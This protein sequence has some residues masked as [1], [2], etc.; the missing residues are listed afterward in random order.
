MTSY[1][2]ANKKNTPAQILYQTWKRALEDCLG[3][4]GTV[5]TRAMYWGE[6]RGWGIAYVDQDANGEPIIGFG[7]KWGS[8]LFQ[9][10]V[11]NRD[12]HFV[13]PALWGGYQRFILAKHTFLDW[14]YNW[15]HY[16]WYYD[17]ISAGTHNYRNSA[18][19]EHKNQRRYMPEKL[20]R[21]RYDYK[22]Q[23]WVRL[24]PT[25]ADPNGWEIVHA[26]DGLD[27]NNIPVRTQAD[28]DKFAVLR[29]RRYARN[30]KA[31]EIAAGIRDDKGKLKTPQLAGERRREA[32]QTLSENLKVSRPAR[33]N[34]LRKLEEE[35]L[36]PPSGCP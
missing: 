6:D 26:Q 11:V 21:R 35:G 31:Y 10:F 7:Q 19:S 25:T 18:L 13:M 2:T 27:S 20:L 8:A 24:A 30:Q 29:E 33:T 5:G 23:V 17:P 1:A 32:V 16:H 28:F 15:G 36:W 9:P 12:G 3:P 34:P 4:Y 22:A 14:S